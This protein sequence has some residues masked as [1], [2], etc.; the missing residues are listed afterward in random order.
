MHLL[1]K[2]WIKNFTIPAIKNPGF[3]KDV[4]IEPH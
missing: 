4:V 1:I 2:P 3:W